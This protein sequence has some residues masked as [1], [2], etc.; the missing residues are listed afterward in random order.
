MWS[1]PQRCI[2]DPVKHLWWRFLSKTAFRHR[3]CLTETYKSYFHHSPCY[4]TFFKQ[5]IFKTTIFL[6]FHF[7]GNT[8]KNFLLSRKW[9]QWTACPSLLIRF[10]IQNLTPD[11]S[12]KV[13]CLLLSYYYTTKYHVP[14]RNFKFWHPR[15]R[16]FSVIYLK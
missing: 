10:W 12:F 4:F 13:R 5:S 15:S 6:F 7:N 8:E 14:G 16:I 1:Y 11:S 3:R 2:C 9:D